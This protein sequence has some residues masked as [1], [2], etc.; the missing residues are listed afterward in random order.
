MTKLTL[1]YHSAHKTVKDDESSTP[2]CLVRVS[3]AKSSCR[4]RRQSK[5]VKSMRK[6]R[7]AR[8]SRKSEKMM[9]SLLFVRRSAVLDCCPFASGDGDECLETSHVVDLGLAVIGSI[10]WIVTS[11]QGIGMWWLDRSLLGEGLE[12]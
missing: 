2:K 8:L 6:C 3:H 12:A 1:G 7:Y 9:W 10:S 5:Y 11:L 4:Y